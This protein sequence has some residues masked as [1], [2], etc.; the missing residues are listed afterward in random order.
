MDFICEK[1]KNAILA[2]MIILLRIAKGKIAIIILYLIANLPR[3]LLMKFRPITIPLIL[4]P[5]YASGLSNY[6]LKSVP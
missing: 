6:T 2:I 4:L 5:D 3:N 1:D